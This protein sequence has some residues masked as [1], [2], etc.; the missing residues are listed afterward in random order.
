VPAKQKFLKD[1][2]LNVQKPE[3]VETKATAGFDDSGQF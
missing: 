1:H 2:V 3:H